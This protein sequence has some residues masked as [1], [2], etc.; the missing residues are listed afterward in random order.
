[1]WVRGQGGEKLRKTKFE[2]RKT[3]DGWKEWWGIGV[4]AVPAGGGGKRREELR[5][6]KEGQ[7][8]EG[9]RSWLMILLYN[10]YI[11]PF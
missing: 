10:M 8:E 3:G 7:G 9:E 11:T 2:K 5:Q 1:M 4:T 6:G